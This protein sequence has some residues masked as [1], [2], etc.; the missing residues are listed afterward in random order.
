[1]VP[2]QRLNKFLESSSFMVAGS[3]VGQLTTPST[4]DNKVQATAHGF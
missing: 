3:L 4:E 1:M 2:H